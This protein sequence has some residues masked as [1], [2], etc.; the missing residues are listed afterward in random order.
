MRVSASASVCLSETQPG[1]CDSAYAQGCCYS[2]ARLTS[3]RDHPVKKGNRMIQRGRHT[4]RCR[5]VGGPQARQHQPVPEVSN[6]LLNS[7]SKPTAFLNLTLGQGAHST[8]PP[9]THCWGRTQG[10]EPARSALYSLAAPV[11]AG[12]EPRNFFVMR[13]EGG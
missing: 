13:V 9:S 12:L 5:G 4:G 7:E 11:L 3:C 2:E 8:S 6:L 10:L 1:S